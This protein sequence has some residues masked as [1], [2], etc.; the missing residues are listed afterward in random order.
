MELEFCA[1]DSGDSNTLDIDFGFG[2]ALTTNSEADIDHADQVQLL[3]FHMDG[4]SDNVL[5]QSDDN[6]TDVAAVDTTIDNDSTTDVPKK[7]KIVIRP[8][9]VG[10]L[11]VAGVRVLSTTVFT[12]LSTALVGAFV[13]MEKTSN[14]TTASIIIGKLRVAAGMAA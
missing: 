10:E 7:Y 9:G 14:D 3:G 2:T 8:T 11:W 12:I 1:P 5:A 4:A 13:N 6:T